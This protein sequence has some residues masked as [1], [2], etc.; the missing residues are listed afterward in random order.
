VESQLRVAEF[1]F[2]GPLRDR[3]VA[4]ILDGTKTS[5]TALLAG[6]E[7]EGLPLP[8]VGRLRAGAVELALVKP[9]ARCV[10]TTIDQRTAQVGREP[11][12]TLARVR[13]GERG[14]MFGENAIPAVVGRIAVG[15]R[16]DVVE[17]RDRALEPVGRASES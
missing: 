14:A 13:R 6:F 9:C 5:T 1:G 3:L 4:A 7:H 11:L 8:R 12:R 10:V 15:D 16:V 2:P 17:T